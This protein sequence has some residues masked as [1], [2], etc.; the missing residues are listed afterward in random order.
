MK[1]IIRFTE[2]G[3]RAF[4]VSEEDVDALVAAKKARHVQGPL[5]EEL[6]YETREMRP[7]KPQAKPVVIEEAPKEEAA[8]KT[9][10][11]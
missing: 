11:E 5:Y 2:N 1:V 6:A 7:K 10:G 9:D 4:P 8:P 3:R